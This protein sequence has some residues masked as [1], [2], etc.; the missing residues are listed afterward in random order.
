MFAEFI[1]CLIHIHVMVSIKINA[2]S[3]EMQAVALDKYYSGLNKR[4]PPGRDLQKRLDEL[5]AKVD[6][7][8]RLQAETGA[9]LKCTAAGGAG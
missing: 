5:H 9:E 3:A 4:A 1:N 7:L 2:L 6:A 8:R